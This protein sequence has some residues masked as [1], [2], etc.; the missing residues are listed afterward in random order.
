M[1]VTTDTFIAE[2]KQL[3]TL[4]SV[5]SRFSNA[6]FFSFGNRKMKDSVVPVIHSLNAE[7]FVTKTDV[8]VLSG[9]VIYPIPARAMGRK[10]REI[11]L[12]N[13]NNNR[14][15][16]PQIAI[17]REQ[18]YRASSLPAGFFFYGDRIELVPTP[19][20]D[21]YS[22]QMWW[23]IPPGLM[24][25]TTDA[26]VVQSINVDDV[27]VVSIPSVLTIGRDIDFIAGQ[28]GNSCL[29][30]DAEILNITGNTLTFATGTV[31]TDLAA[32]DYI[33]IAQTS[34]VLQIP[35]DAVPYLVTLT[36]MEMLGAI[37]D[38]DGMERLKETRDDQKKNLMLLLEPRA[39]GEPIPLINDYGFIGGP[40]RGIWGSWGYL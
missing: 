35:D 22:L 16:L 4:P 32:G 20:A 8:P 40:R 24:V 30:I 23:F 34:P 33:S 9:Q 14:S 7:F 6:N 15:D 12:K 13:P 29:G 27:T 26:A 39:E 38:Y 11:K 37:S 1:T 25:P 10:L 3:I 28:A 2:V 31:P 18:F 17:E 36:A 21:G 5:Q 19:T